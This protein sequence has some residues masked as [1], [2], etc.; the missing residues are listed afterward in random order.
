MS[1]LKKKFLKLKWISSIL[2]FLVGCIVQCVVLENINQR[3]QKQ[4]Q[5]VTQLNAMT[6]AERMVGD[7]QSGRKTKRIESTVDYRSIDRTF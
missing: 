4:V 6:Y 7:L 5:T 3:N 1:R 2:V